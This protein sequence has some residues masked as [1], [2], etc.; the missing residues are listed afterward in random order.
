MAPAE[1]ARLYRAADCLLHPS[2]AEGFPLV[3]QEAMA[4]GLPAVIADDPGY[5]PHLADAPHGV[6]RVARDTEAL[7]NALRSIDLGRAVPAED[8]S[9]LAEFARSRFSWERSAADHEALY[10]KLLDAPRT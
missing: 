4:S 5:E 6:L 7:V 1:V 3:L 8:R 2:Q 10:R 9:A